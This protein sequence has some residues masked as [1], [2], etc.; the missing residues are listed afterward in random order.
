M[1]VETLSAIVAIGMSLAFSYIPGLGPWYAPLPSE[2]KQLIM[3]GAL[4]VV[5]LGVVGLACTGLAADFGLNI[6]CDRAGVLAVVRAFIAALVANQA[7][8]KLTPQRYPLE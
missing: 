8:Y 7:A 4:F 2:K 1:T 5:S 6:T 3:L